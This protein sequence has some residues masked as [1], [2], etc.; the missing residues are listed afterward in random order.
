[1]L[2]STEPDTYFLRVRNI[3]ARRL[4]HEA[5]R[6]YLD[7]QKEIFDGRRCQAMLVWSNGML[8]N[9][10]ET[11]DLWLNGFE[12]HRDDD[13]RALFESL[14][15]ERFLPMGFTLAMLTNI[16]LDRARAVVEIGNAIYALR[17]NIVVTP[18]AGD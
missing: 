4:D 17:R 13:K 9:S 11:L 3:V 7:R 12:Y 16:M 6:A 14:H 5:F 18:L 8:V 1:V 2:Q 15:D 10:V